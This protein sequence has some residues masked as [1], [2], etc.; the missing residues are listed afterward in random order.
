MG[1]GRNSNLDVQIV[2]S[3]IEID[4]FFSFYTHDLKKPGAHPLPPPLL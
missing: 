1:G 4:I 3:K 2:N